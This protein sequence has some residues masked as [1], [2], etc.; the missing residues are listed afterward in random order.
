MLYI[1]VRYTRNP[2]KWVWFSEEKPLDMGSF[3]QNINKLVCLSSK[4]PR[5]LGVRHVVPYVVKILWG[6][7][8]PFTSAAT[9]PT[10][11]NTICTFIPNCVWFKLIWCVIKYRLKCI[12]Y[13]SEWNRLCR[14]VT[15]LPLIGWN[16]QLGSNNSNTTLVECC[17][18]YTMWLCIIIIVKENI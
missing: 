3:F 2:L 17:D 11:T 9:H 12:F 4:I 18:R 7:C 1:F 15:T 14:I 13:P 8:E 16:V 6:V 10:Y 5:F